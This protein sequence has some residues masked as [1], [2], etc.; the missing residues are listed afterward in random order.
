MSDSLMPADDAAR[1]TNAPEA[2]VAGPSAGTLLRVARENAGLHIAALAVALKVPV[3]KIEALEADR[4][5]ALPDAVFVRALAA[6]VCRTLKIEPQ[7]VLDKLPGSSTP[8][9]MTDA[10]GINTPFR[11]S[12]D[13]ASPSWRGLLSKPL[14]LGVI[15]LLIGAAVLV[16][17]PHIQTALSG[18]NESAVSLLAA[19][20]EAPIPGSAATPVPSNATPD[21]APIASPASAPMQLSTSASLRL[22]DATQTSIV[23][24]SAPSAQDA[25]RPTVNGPA[26]GGL[27]V[28]NTRSESWV[29]V[30]DARGQVVL[31]R[32]L[33]AGQSAGASGTLPLAVVVGRADATQVSVRGQP[34]DLAA[35]SRDNVARFEVK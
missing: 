9:L 23:F 2:V 11:M 26:T 5:D 16:F 10:S 29:E 12:S 28:F 7:P 34:M 13:V 3:K 18:L 27:V 8:R 6:S 17:L 33:G 4:Y 30:T 25:A 35:V 31:R 20:E 21:E 1:A 19:K 32:T 15:A 14:F 22:A 24:P